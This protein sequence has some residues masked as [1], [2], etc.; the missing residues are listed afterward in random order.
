MGNP[1]RSM[2]LGQKDRNFTQVEAKVLRSARD[3]EYRVSW[4]PR[5]HNLIM[6]MKLLSTSRATFM[7]E[8]SR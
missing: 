1:Q 5:G 2:S 8:A 6:I 3:L 4:I 7:N